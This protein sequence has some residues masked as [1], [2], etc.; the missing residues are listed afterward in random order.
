MGNVVDHLDSWAR[1][2]PDRLLFAFLDSR[3]HVTASYTYR[4]FQLRTNHL[5][6]ELQKTGTVATGQPV[7]LVYPPGLEFAVAFYAAVKLGAIP[8]PVPPPVSSNPQVGLAKLAHVI[9]NSGARV[10]LTEQ[11]LHSRLHLADRGSNV[12]FSLLGAKGLAAVEWVATD[13]DAG[14]LEHFERCDRE[15]LF[16]QY[17]SGSTR[18]PRGVAVSHE[19]IVHNCKLALDHDRPVGVSWLPHFHDMGLI[20]YLLW[21]VIRGGCSYCFSPMDFLRRPAL[22]LEAITKFKATITTAPNFAFDYC[23][24]EDKIPARSLEQFELSTIRQLVNAAEPVRAASVNRFLARFAPCGLDGRS[25]TTAFGLAEHT[26]CVTGGG[27]VQIDVNRRLIER[28]ELRVEA[29]SGKPGRTF[30]LVSCGKPDDTVDLRIVDPHTLHARGPGEVGEIWVDSPSK[31]R[32]YWGQP[33]LSGEVFEA[34]ISGSVSRAGYL[35]TG[36]MGFVH[37]GELFVCGRLKDM[38]VVCGQNIYPNDIEAFVEANLSNVVLGSVVVFGVRPHGDREGIAVLIEA[39]GDG[40]FPELTDIAREVTN[41]CQAPVRLVA[42]VARGSIARTSSGKISRAR[43]EE[44]WRSGQI[45][46]LDIFEPAGAP[47][48][49]KTADEYLEEIFR[50]GDVRGDDNLTLEELGFDSFELVTLSL[51]L[52]EFIEAHGLQ[53][54]QLAI[55]VNDLRVIQSITIAHLKLLVNEVN[56]RLPNIVKIGRMSSR[57]IRDIVDEEEAL[58][59]RDAQLASDIQPGAVCR[60]AGGEDILITGATGFL[61]AHLLHALLCLTRADIHVLVRAQDA[62]HGHNRIEAA[63][64][65]AIGGDTASAQGLLRRVRILP[66]DLAKPRLGL[67]EDD[68]N[69]LSYGVSSIYHCGA[70]VDYVRSYRAMRAANVDGT[71]EIIRLACTGSTK[72]LHHISTTFIFGWCAMPRLYETAYDGGMKDRDFG[73]A[74]TKWVAEQLVC[75]AVSRGLDA[76]TYRSSL[77]TASKGGH[78]VRSDIVARVLGYMIRHGISTTATNQM[79]FLPVDHCASNI[80][81]ISLCDDVQPATFHVTADHHY[82]IA[83]VCDIIS[84]RFGYRFDY[85]DMDG[86]VRHMNVHCGPDDELYPLKPFITKH[87]ERVNR[88]QEKRYDNR[89]YRLARKCAV[90]ASDEPSLQDIAQ[91]IVGFLQDQALVPLPPVQGL[92]GRVAAQAGSPG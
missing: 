47:K 1:E 60:D 30:R 7:L 68:W 33:K 83:D 31:A 75:E 74:Q 52:D 32:G 18:D 67:D 56:S 82:A 4:Q 65:S 21:A 61:G 34:R 40:P 19:N 35:R 27:R 88:M 59:R 2:T 73:Y 72:R 87:V 58:M 66:G 49:E 90:G 76:R 54:S 71:R 77:V 51:H 62:E 78:Y 3:A 69:R 92:A 6:A 22:W 86:F 17:T 15:T 53:D 70:E 24:R 23:L 5:A 25:F 39:K 81:A 64:L 9:V 37:D 16:L 28:N 44:R 14:K 57:A 13:E 46:V 48:V 91:W 12:D 29:V 43:C 26:L 80:A 55:D 85:T 8:V 42:L 10:A 11:R 84:D 36:D 79:S 41:G 63:L 45:D 89:N 20:G 38:V 50:A